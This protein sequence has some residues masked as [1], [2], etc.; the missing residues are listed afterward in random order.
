MSEDIGIGVIGLGMG[1]HVLQVNRDPASR[2]TV[3]G[4]CDLDETTLASCAGEYGINLTTTHYEELLRRDDIQMIGVY[5]PDHLHADQILAALAAGKHVIVTKPMVNTM[6]EAEQVIAA[7]RTS[8][9]T[10]LVAQTQ[11]FKPEYMAARRL[12]DNGEVG[13]VI[14]VQTGY[15]HDMRPVLSTPGRDWRRDP[16]KKDWLVGA[17]CHAIDLALWFGGDVETVSASANKGSVL[18]DRKGGNNFLINLEF[19]NGAV[20][21]VLV[22]FSVVRPPPGL[23]TLSVCGTRASIV[24]S[25][26]SRDGPDGVVETDLPAPEDEGKGHANETTRILRHM[27]RCIAGDESPLVDAVQAAKTLAV[28]LAAKAS[29]EEGQSVPARMEF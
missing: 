26:I 4:I 13:D 14:F 11:R 25:R 17:A 12:L 15:V 27:E 2:M 8:G 10:L 29:I 9:R 19:R 1:K 5:S 23:D 3:R 22:L 18:P 7:V 6:A 16:A 24:G 21:R 28:A 20:G